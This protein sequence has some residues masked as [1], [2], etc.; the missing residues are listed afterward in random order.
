MIIRLLLLF[1]Q[2][3]AIV[4]KSQVKKP[5]LSNLIGPAHRGE[6]WAVV[7]FHHTLG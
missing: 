3:A 7:V 5:H 1:N 2:Q 4:Q 6:L